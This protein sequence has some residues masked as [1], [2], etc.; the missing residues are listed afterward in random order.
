MVIQMVCSAKNVFRKRESR[1][2]GFVLFLKKSLN[3]LC[4][5]FLP[6]L[7]TTFL[8]YFWLCVGF[9][10]IVKLVVMIGSVL[11]VGLCKSVHAQ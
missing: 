1:I 9:A 10:A 3:W 6:P 5:M 8:Q 2:R 4:M 11:L 7:L